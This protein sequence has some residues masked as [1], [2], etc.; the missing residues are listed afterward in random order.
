MWIRWGV[1]LAANAR[2]NRRHT[3]LS[4]DRRRRLGR[5]FRLAMLASAYCPQAH[6]SQPE[7][8]SAVVVAV[9]RI[10]PA[11]VSV[12]TELR[13]TPQQ[14]AFGWFFRDL[15]SADP[16]RETTSQGSGVVIEPRG[17]VLTNYHV[18]ATGGDIELELTDGQRLAAEVVGSSP[19]HDLAV[20]RVKTKQSL[21]YVKMGVSHD[22]MIGETVIAIGNPFG[23]AQTVTTGVVSALHRT[24]HTEERDYADFIQTDASI[25]PGN[26]GG[27]L[28]TID[29]QLMGVNT[30]I[31]S[32]AQGI[33]FAIPIDKAKRIVE[34]LLAYGE[35]RRPYYGFEFQEL[36]PNLRIALHLGDGGGALVAD[37]DKV[38][39][40]RT[41]VREGDVIVRVDGAQVLDQASLR[42]LL[43]DY[44]V[45]ASLSVCLVREG[46]KKTITLTPGELAPDEALRRLK[47][48]VGLSVEALG[49]GPVAGPHASRPPEGLLVV[50]HVV[51][52][53]PAAQIGIRPGDFVRAVNSEKIMGMQA[54]CRALARHYW[55]GQVI[56]LIQRGRVWQQVP[57][58]F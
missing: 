53:S 46:A 10:S 51:P 7:R 13:V 16:R 32:N 1:A 35:V 41:S 23:L 28:L 49:R 40:S 50:R 31:Y 18:I 44:T 3:H 57:F 56:I 54:F 36:T 5:I 33:G 29:G 12:R 39:P 20:L 47:T 34:D 14:D 21:P 43:G 45:G 17:L 27:P 2:T 11:V 24:L 38:G 58:A 48:S 9:E 25:N 19:E 15:A 8:R 55:S 52:R 30:A 22:L 4:P 42:L 37:V 6:A 26:S